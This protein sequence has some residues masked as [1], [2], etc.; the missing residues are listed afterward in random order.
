[1]EENR[2]RLKEKASKRKVRIVRKNRILLP[3]SANLNEMY[4][5]LELLKRGC[6]KVDG[7]GL[8]VGLCTRF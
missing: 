6:I 4:M 7:V 5:S 3:E 8:A 2:K 1:M